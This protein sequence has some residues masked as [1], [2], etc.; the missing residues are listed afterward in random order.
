MNNIE[1]IVALL[2]ATPF[3]LKDEK[4]L[5][6][7]IEDVLIA[8]GIRNKRE[9]KLSGSDIVDFMLEGGIAVEVKLA[10][11]KRAIY[12]QCERYCEHD[13]VKVIVLMTA[14][15]MGFPPEIKGKPAYYVSLG[16]SW[17]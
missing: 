7:S 6:A 5:Q 10:G 15:T 2:R 9:V 8:N 3:V 11:Q 13:A 1:D 12:R 14:K 17:L 16:R 4:S